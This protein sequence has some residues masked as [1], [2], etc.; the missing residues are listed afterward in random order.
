MFVPIEIGIAGERHFEVLDGLQQGEQV[1]IGPF[2]VL[3]SLQEGDRVETQTGALA[4]R[5]EDE[6]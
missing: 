1:I 3:R 2:D 5:A 4:R 6:E